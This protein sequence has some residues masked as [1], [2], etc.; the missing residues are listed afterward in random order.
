MKAVREALLQRQRDYRRPPGLVADGRD[1]GTTIFPFADV[2][3]FLTAS[4][5]V[6]AKR[7]YKQLID[8]GLHV[9]LPALVNEIAERDARDSQRKSSPL[10]PAS[11]AVI[12]DTTHLTIGD[13]FAKVLTICNQYL[14]R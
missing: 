12:V 6:R 3:I 2:K 1:M 8:K 14:D 13:V 10:R 9:T 7:R 4:A 5:E 11:D